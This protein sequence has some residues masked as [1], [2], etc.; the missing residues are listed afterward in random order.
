MADSLRRTE[1]IWM[2]GKRYDFNVYQSSVALNAYQYRVNAA[3]TPERQQKNQ[4]VLHFTAGNGPGQGSIEWWNELAS[5]PAWICPHYDKNPPHKWG[6]GFRYKCPHNGPAHTWEAD[7][8]VCPVHNT[9]VAITCPAGHGAL[10]AGKKYASAHSTVS[11][12]R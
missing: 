6:Y 1:P 4:I 5:R 3:G 7:S 10:V 8:G 11:A 12:A 2:F 9:K